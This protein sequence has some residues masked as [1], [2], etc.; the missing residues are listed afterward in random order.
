M[1]L[2]TKSRG[3]WAEISGWHGQGRGVMSEFVDADCQD[4]LVRVPW[5]V[6]AALCGWESCVG[7]IR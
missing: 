5:L 2:G 7:G 4:G 3:G 6:A 1:W